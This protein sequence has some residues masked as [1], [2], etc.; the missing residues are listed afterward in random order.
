MKRK[1]IIKILNKIGF[2]VDY[3]GD[4]LFMDKEL[5][6][7]SKSRYQYFNISDIQQHLEENEK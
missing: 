4:I 5:F 3:Y 7:V 2:E 1:K 6:S